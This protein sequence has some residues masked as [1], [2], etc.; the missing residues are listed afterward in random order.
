MISIQFSTRLYSAMEVTLRNSVDGWGTDI[1][2]TYVNGAWVF[3]LGDTKYEEGFQ[4]KFFLP[5][6][7]AWSYGPNLQAPADSSGMIAFD[8]D[9]VRF[10]FFIELDAGDY[11]TRGRFSLRS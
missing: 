6:Q 2:G 10:L 3:Q 9:T 1:H 11:F 8:A 7:Q 4:F 5:E